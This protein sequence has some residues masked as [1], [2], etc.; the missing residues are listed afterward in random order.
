MEVVGQGKGVPV[1]ALAVSMALLT[2]V[3]SLIEDKFSCTG[4][5]EGSCF[6]WNFW[7]PGVLG[8][9]SHR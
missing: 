3:A 4:C 7:R 9:V 8:R 6:V 1:L 2:E 5:I